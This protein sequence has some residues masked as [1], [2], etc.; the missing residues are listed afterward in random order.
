MLVIGLTKLE[1]KVISEF[2]NVSAADWVR[3]SNL[4]DIELQDARLIKVEENQLFVVKNSDNNQQI[5]SF[6]SSRSGNGTDFRKMNAEG[7]GYQPMLMNVKQVM[8]TQNA[9]L[10]KIEVILK[11][12]FKGKYYWYAK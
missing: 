11:D 10:I 4:L 9:A 8:I 1:A 2:K 6:G 3:F 7:L 12:G 5:I